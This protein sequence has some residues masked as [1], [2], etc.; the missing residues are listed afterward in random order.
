[1]KRVIVMKILA[2]NGSARKRGNTDILI[3]QI[4]K[5]SK[6]GKHTTQKLYLYDYEILPCMDCRDCKKGDY[7]CILNDGMKKIYPKMEKADLIIFG[8]PNYW[9]GPTGK[10]KLLIDR[11]RPFVPSRKLK[12]KKWVIVSPSGEGPN[13]CRLLVEMFHLSCD[14]L[15]MKF[16]GKVLAKAYEKGEIKKNQKALKKTFYFGISL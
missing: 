14:Y 12:G 15:G 11:M 10:M 5:G 1:M 8:T 3:D 4:L 13:S 7:V 9:N 6:R 16:A 2:L